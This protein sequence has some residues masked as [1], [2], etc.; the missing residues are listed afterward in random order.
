MLQQPTVYLSDVIDAPIHKIWAIARDFNGLSSYHPL[1]LESTI[2][3]HKA[4]DSIGAIRY[5]RLETGFVREQLLMLD[6]SQHQ[7]CYGIIESSLPVKNYIAT[8]RFTPVTEGER[9][10]CEWFAHFEVVD[11][12]LDAMIELVGQAV[13]KVG[14][15]SLAK[16][17]ARTRSI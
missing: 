5:L 6:D 2:E 3:N 11:G 12:S 8:V 4:S 9:T 17:V 7:F 10:F 16:V 14:F 13:F 15:Q 1:I